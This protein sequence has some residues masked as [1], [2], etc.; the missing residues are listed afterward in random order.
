MHEQEQLLREEV[1]FLAKKI[2][3]T[4]NCKTKW[5]IMTRRYKQS[6]GTQRHA[7][8][9]RKIVYQIISKSQS[10]KILLIVQSLEVHVVVNSQSCLLTLL[11]PDLQWPGARAGLPGLRSQSTVLC[12]LTAGVHRILD[13]L[14]LYRV[15]EDGALAFHP[16]MDRHFLYFHPGNRK[17]ERGNCFHKRE[18][19]RKTVVSYIC[20]QRG[21][22]NTR[23]PS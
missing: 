1:P 14:Q 12:F 13:A 4:G 15:S 10:F 19:R 17:D 21:S 9:K 22:W 23:D 2:Q 7:G 18:Q 11:C 3:E 6:T 8:I 16:G 5:C 20:G